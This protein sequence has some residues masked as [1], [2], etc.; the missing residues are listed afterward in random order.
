MQ[1]ADLPL[2]ASIAAGLPRKG[3]GVSLVTQSGSYG[4][5]AHALGQD[6]GLRVAK[7]YAAGNKAD[8]SDAEILGYLRAD[9]ATSV[10]CLLLESVTDGRAF[11][12][13]ACLT[14]Q[15]KPVIAVVGGA[16]ARA[17]APPCRTPPRS[18]PM[19]PS[20][21]RRCGRLASPGRAPGCR[22]STP[23]V[24]CPPSRCH[25]AAGWRC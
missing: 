16:P 13:Q 19:T 24:P 14:T 8:I 25:A 6:E 12:A 17:S 5:A 21:T 10:I 22:R 11:F 3:G 23:P 18:R 4:M 9:P 2:N 1:N 15:V 7:V 20:A